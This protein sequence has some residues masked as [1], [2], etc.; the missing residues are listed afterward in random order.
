LEKIPLRQLAQTYGYVQAGREVFLLLAPAGNTEGRGT[1]PLWK[2]EA[3]VQ[4]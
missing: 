3:W 4:R 1:R 2:G